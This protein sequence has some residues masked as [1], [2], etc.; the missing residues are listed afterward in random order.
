MSSDKVILA[1]G[2]S[3]LACLLAIMWQSECDPRDMAAHDYAK[4]KMKPHKMMEYVSKPTMLSTWFQWIRDIRPTGPR[5]MTPGKTFLG[6]FNVGPLGPYYIL[7]N[8]TDYVPGKVLAMDADSW[9]RPQLRIEVEDLKD[10]GCTLHLNMV[11]NRTSVL[12]QYTIGWMGSHMTHN[13]FRHALFML[14]MMIHPEAEDHHD[15]HPD[16]LHHEL[17]L[18]HLEDMEGVEVGEEVRLPLSGR[19]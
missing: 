19:E 9:L 1:Y 4:F 7:L 10:D 8:V 12:F 5:F 3:A 15:I 16:D 13:Q 11:F 2:L 14:R 17:D 6:E 18:S